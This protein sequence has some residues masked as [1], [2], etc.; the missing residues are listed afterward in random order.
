MVYDKAVY[1]ESEDSQYNSK[2]VT[3]DKEV[4]IYALDNKM[5][6]PYIMLEAEIIKGYKARVISNTMEKKKFIQDKTPKGYYNVYLRSN[7]GVV[8]LGMVHSDNLKNLLLSDLY[9]DMT[10][11]IMLTM[12]DKVEGEMM[13]S[14]CTS[15][16]Y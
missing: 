8:C 9:S 6:Y 4:K 13:Y 3:D 12:E 1:Y 10:K 15:P 2:A 5:D 11:Y 7:G 16:L 14:Y